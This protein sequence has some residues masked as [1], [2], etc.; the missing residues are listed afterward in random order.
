MCDLHEFFTLVSVLERRSLRS[1]QLCQ[2]KVVLTRNERPPDF[3]YPVNNL[4]NVL[5]DGQTLLL[6]VNSSGFQSLEGFGP[7]MLDLM[8]LEL[9]FE[10]ATE[11]VSENDHEINWVL[12]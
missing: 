2:V 4:L 9:N 10:A 6:K 5:R 3:S 8:R 7:E 12:S 11:L 1:G